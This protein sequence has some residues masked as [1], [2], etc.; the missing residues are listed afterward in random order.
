MEP[1][2]VLIGLGIGFIIGSLIFYTLSKFSKK[3]PKEKA[4]TPSTKPSLTPQEKI[5]QMSELE[6]ARKEVNALLLEKELLSGALT[7]VYEAEVQ[8]KI[9]KEE[10]EQLSNKYREQLKAVEEKLSNVE[11]L[12]EVG[13][14][15]SLRN[16]L[17]G[18]FERKIGQIESRLDKAKVKLEEIKGISKPPIPAKLERK[19]EKPKIKTEEARV[20]DRV[21]ALREE[22]LQALDRLEQIDIEK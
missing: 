3:Q 15:E 21:K 9:T 7:R 19:E 22:V 11:L 6:K 16:E 10:R 17:I 14:L 4:E 12:I 18:L 8:N 20:E 1:F 5:I 13:E 2:D